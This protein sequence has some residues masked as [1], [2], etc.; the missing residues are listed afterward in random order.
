MLQSAAPSPAILSYY[1]RDYKN[2]D[3]FVTVCADYVV[4]MLFTSLEKQEWY[5]SAV[6]RNLGN[7]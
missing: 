4:Q 7:H 2:R 6:P 5:G 1:S 3:L